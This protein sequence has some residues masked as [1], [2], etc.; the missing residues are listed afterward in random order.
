MKIEYRLLNK[1]RVYRGSFMKVKEIEMIGDDII[2]DVESIKSI[3]K[4]ITWHKLGT[5]AACLC[6]VVVSA[7]TFLSSILNTQWKP[8]WPI[9][10][11]PISRQSEWEDSILPRW[12]ELGISQQYNELI[13]NGKTYY[14]TIKKINKDKLGASVGREALSG[15]DN[16]TQEIK[17]KDGTIYSINGITIECVVAVQFNDDGDYYVYRNS[18]YKPNTLGQLI[19]DLNLRNNMSFGSVWY[20]YQKG[21]GENVTIE[22]VDLQNSVVWNMLLKDE[23]IVNVKNYDSICFNSLMSVSVNIPV[24]GYENISLSVS[25][26]GYITTNILDTGKAFYIGKDKV[27]A[28]VDYVL[29]N[30]KGY[31]IEYIDTKGTDKPE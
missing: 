15:Q 31:E 1:L 20:N 21:D 16:Y 9:K 14:G 6:I 23:S 12:E 17:H 18:Y 29:K 3:H 5:I 7:V 30:C 22:F 11:L 26:N 19:R 2:A 8:S 27:N 10:E 13:F 24:L 28:F 25:D 4:K